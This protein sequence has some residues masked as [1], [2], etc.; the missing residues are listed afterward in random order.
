MKRIYSGEYYTRVREFFELPKLLESGEGT[1]F[2]A[3]REVLQTIIT[4]IAKENSGIWLDVGGG[5]GAFANLVRQMKPGWA[6]RLN[7]S[8]PLSVRIAREQLGLEV[9]TE[10][11]AALLLRDERFDVI[12]SVAVLEHIPNPVSFLTGYTKL[13]K[14]GGWLITVVPQFT[15]LNSFVSQASSAN[16]VPPYHVSLFSE[17]TLRRLM[18]RVPGLELVRMEQAGPAA[19]DLLDHVQFGDHWDVEFPSVEHPVPHSLQIRK[20]HQDQKNALQALSSVREQ[21]EPY[22]ADHDGRLYLIAYCQC[23]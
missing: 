6:V 19:F 14:P 20:Y 18:L 3:P 8:N 15:R 11:A 1:P 10:D 23:F 7:E 22:F 16:V 13:L 17:S 12:S 21:L 5:L 4:Q 2:S 9:V